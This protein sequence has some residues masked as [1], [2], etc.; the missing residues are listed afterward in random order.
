[1]TQRLAQLAARPACRVEVEARPQAEA[2]DAVE[3]ACVDEPGEPVLERGAELARASLRLAR[4]QQL[5]D[6]EP[7]RARERVAAER[8]AVRPGR[9]H[10]EHVAPPDD[11]RDRHDPAAERLAE[12]HEVGSHAPRLGR[13]RRPGA[14]EAGL[15]LV[16]HE[17]HVPRGRDRAQARPVVVGRHD[18]ARLALHRL[19]EHGD[20]RV[21][22]RGGDRVG[23]A[24]RHEAEPQR[25]RVEPAPGVGVVGERHDRRRAAVEVPGADDDRR[26]ARGHALDVVAPLARRLDR[27]LDG[28]RAR[29]HREHEG[30][31]P[32]RGEGPDER[33][34][35][36]GE[37]VQEVVVERARRERDAT[38]LARGGVD[39]RG[40]PVPEVERRVPREEVEVA[41]TG[42][43]GDPRPLRARDRHGQRVVVVRERA[44]AG[45]VSGPVAVE[46]AGGAARAR[47][48]VRRADLLG[49]H[50][51][52]PA[53]AGAWTAGSRISSVQH[54]APP[55]PRRSSDVST[56]TVS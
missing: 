41:A 22:D 19:Q 50:D 20:G 32:A 25:V 45:A 26:L 37:R 6:R 1:M 12:G 38:E 36:L 47:A 27:G 51:A 3:Q 55:P 7:D 42:H 23:V 14:P 49:G 10:L 43:V 40:V 34:E 56:A 2:A 21:V 9:E 31:G 8:A 52:L 46:R 4:A 33:G 53:G 5:D 30:V 15:D 54:F 24:V 44:A 35:R 17:E 16:G 29:V 18:D 39:E 13:E 28:L 11:G 48:A